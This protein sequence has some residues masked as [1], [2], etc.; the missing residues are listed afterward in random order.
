MASKV[1]KPSTSDGLRPA[2]RGSEPLRLEWEGSVTL[3]LRSRTQLRVREGDPTWSS[4]SAEPT[5]MPPQGH[6]W[7]LTGLGSTSQPP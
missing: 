6:R 5:G 4:A 7:S 3:R 2:P 1:A